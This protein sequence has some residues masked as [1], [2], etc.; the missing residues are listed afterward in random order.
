MKTAVI[1][2]ASAGIGAA[3]ARTFARE[4]LHV[5]LAA[6]R[7]DRL[8][9]VVEQIRAAGGQASAV[10]ADV[11][12]EA[13]MERLVADTIATHGRLDVMVCNAGVGFNGLLED[14]PTEVMRRLMDVNFFGTFYAARAAV[15][16][17]RTTGHGHL[18]I[19]SSIVGR[20]GIPRGGAY[21]A[22]K[23]AQVGL[24]EAVRAELA[25]T[26]IHVTIVH[27]ISTDTEFRQAMARE[28][29]QDVRG[30]GPR[31]TPESVARA[32]ARS[33]ERPRADIYPFAGTRLVGVFSALVPRVADRITARFAR[34]P[35]ADHE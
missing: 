3:C 29:G 28:F 15:R 32:M 12:S 33:L 14:T 5:V 25:G 20:R 24:G 6:R 34:R 18:F 21:A 16:H 22:T 31:Q 35:R 30:A 7:G 27:P 1:T 13:D 17:F 11:T 9:E 4:G 23:F 19:V 8:A 2:G 26:D 10:V